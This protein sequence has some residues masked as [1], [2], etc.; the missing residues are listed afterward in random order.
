MRRWIAALAAVCVLVPLGAGADEGMWTLDRFPVAAV[1]QAY[2][3]T[4]TPALLERIEHASLG[5]P[6]C[7]ASFVSPNG[8]V[9]TDQHCIR[10]C[11]LA[12]S[13]PTND[14][15]A[16]GFTAAELAD[17]RR[18]PGLTVESLVSIR[19]VTA[20]VNAATA[21]TT[22][23]AFND[24]LHAVRSQ[25]E[26]S[27]AAPLRCRLVTLYGGGVYDLYAYRERDDVRLAFAPEE[28]IA[29]F[30][31]DEDNFNFPRYDLDCALLRV[32]TN[33]RPL[34]P[35]AYFPWSPNGSRDG[36]LVFTAGDPGTSDRLETM[37][38][39]RDYDAQL[40]EAVRFLD[41]E[42]GVLSEFD[43]ESPE[44]ARMGQT[45]LFYMENQLKVDL[46]NQRALGDPVAM[47]RKAAAERDFRARIE[48][49]PALRA[50]YGDAWDAIA[51]AERRAAVLHPTVTWR[52]FQGARGAYLS[53]ARILVRAA[54]ERT[55][56]S[57]QRLPA[58]SDAALPE[59]RA[60]LA[61]AN[62]VFPPLERALL[63]FN[64]GQIRQHLGNADPY[65]RA[66]LGSETPEEV[67]ARVVDGSKLDDP[68]VRTA[69]FD[70]G[71]AA[72]AASEDPAIVLMR[73][74]DALA[75]ETYRRYAAEVE[76][77][78]AKNS[79]RI[80][81]AYFATY[82]TRVAPDAT[83]TLRVS[84]GRIRSYLD[85]GMRLGP[86]TTVGGAFDHASGGDPFALPASWL[87]AKP[88]LDLRTPL[89]FVSALDTTGG[90]SGSPLFDAQGRI[91]GLEFDGNRFSLSRP[92]YYDDRASRTIAVDSQAIL[93]ALRSIYHAGRLAD[94][95][96]KN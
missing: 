93:L 32:Y 18:C 36:E 14:L 9:L 82:G 4:V 42:R 25:L 10:A 12:L 73:R 15:I 49:V 1:R 52:E 27:C 54:A 46:G 11:L 96:T 33:G 77:P 86:Y 40:T 90:D 80:G 13:T 61:A 37:A 41:E 94:E 66:L 28:R 81:R 68:A 43:R 19:H 24:R 92:Y 87:A 89:N 55:K 7:S 17:E 22:G 71:A 88:A 70:G 29:S 63:A 69:L 60:Q 44:Q 48:R 38:Q 57:A 50:A 53:V 5:M 58:Y 79:E 39:L 67:A 76:A 23:T 2:G 72:I 6:R 47:A 26:S 20:T 31:G 78:I 3:V 83:G 95:L 65:V 8:L 56:P 74:V 45:T 84:Y 62:P 59:L 85:D 30:G 16:N 51:A 64:L 35:P 34:T 91:V 21:G 75:R